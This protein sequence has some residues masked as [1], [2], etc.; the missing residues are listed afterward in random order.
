MTDTAIHEW[1]FHGR[2][3]AFLA[4]YRERKVAM[5]SDH[6]SVTYWVHLYREM[7]PEV[8]ASMNEAKDFIDAELAYWQWHDVDRYAEPEVQR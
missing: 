4:L 5:F 6:G 3:P 7:D 2:K 8:F 1:M